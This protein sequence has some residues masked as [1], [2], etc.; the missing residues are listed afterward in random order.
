MFRRQFLEVVTET[1]GKVE[2]G[3]YMARLEP[4]QRWTE[5]WLMIFDATTASQRAGEDVS[6]DAQVDGSP[7]RGRNGGGVSV[8]R[9]IELAIALATT[10]E[11][12]V[13]GVCGSKPPIGSE[14]ISTIGGENGSQERAHQGSQPFTNDSWQIGPHTRRQG[15]NPRHFSRSRP[16]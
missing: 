8:H 6:L 7:A 4:W 15:A 1:A 16:A 9:L 11:C 5:I 10:A 2:T 13:I 14:A 12:G 3:T